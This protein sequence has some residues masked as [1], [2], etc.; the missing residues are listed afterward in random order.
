MSESMPNEIQD[1]VFEPAGPAPE[2]AA[3][4][5]EEINIPSIIDENLPAPLIFDEAVPVDIEKEPIIL[6]QPAEMINIQN[7]V[8]RKAE[9][10][11]KIEQLREALRKST[12][13]NNKNSQSNSTT[14]D[15][16]PS[17][18]EVNKENVDQTQKAED[19]AFAL[20]VDLESQIN[21]LKL[22]NP[23]SKIL[24]SMPGDYTKGQRE[25]TAKTYIQMLEDSRKRITDISNA[26]NLTIAK[27]KAVEDITPIL[28]KT[29]PHLGMWE[30][31]ITGGNG[32]TK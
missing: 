3:A 31:F 8:H 5:T 11:A 13:E 28:A 12:P 19:A 7:A 32:Y 26:P 16:I 9:D 10:A 18:K 1:A 21:N 25:V 15:S 20:K 29:K 6:E 22:E 14:I 27:V 30:R 2:V 4:K 24:Y 17:Q 23:K